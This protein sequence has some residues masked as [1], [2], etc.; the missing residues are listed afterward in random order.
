MSQGSHL[1][2]LGLP[3]E[4]VHV[5]VRWKRQCKQAYRETLD[6]FYL[7]D[8]CGLNYWIKRCLHRPFHQAFSL[9]DTIWTRII[10]Q[11]WLPPKIEKSYWNRKTKR[12]NLVL[13]KKT[14]LYVYLLHVP[15]EHSEMLLI[16]I[17]VKIF[18]LQTEMNYF[19]FVFTFWANR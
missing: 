7:W 16:K 10:L 12:K 4:N 6:L 18:W 15:T 8:I 11:R 17:H 14:F 5:F 19:R 13:F 9:S 2:Y 1:A 3:D